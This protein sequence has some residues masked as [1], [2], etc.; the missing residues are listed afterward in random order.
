MRLLYLVEE[1]DGVRL[2]AYSLRQLS[3]LVISYVSR[4]GADKACSGEL[5]L[6]LTHIY[7]GEHSLVVEED[8]RQRLRQLRLPH[9][10]STEEDEGA[11]RSLR[12]L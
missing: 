6:I 10:G 11:D 9:P 4:R 8:L 7:T 12:V 5:L 3:T 1:N 2:A